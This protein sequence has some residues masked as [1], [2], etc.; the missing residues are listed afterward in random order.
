MSD[1]WE[2]WTDDDFNIPVLNVP[3]KEQLKQLE[4]R[5]MVEESDNAL[6]K[7]LFSGEEDLAYGEIKKKEQKNFTPLQSTEKKAPK[8]NVSSKQKENEQKQK[9]MSKK[10]KEEKKIKQKLRETFGEADEDNE[11]AEYEDMFY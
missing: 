1:N 8:K 10:I 9:E 3:N 11:Y 5:K 4:D 2:D 7:D 6:T